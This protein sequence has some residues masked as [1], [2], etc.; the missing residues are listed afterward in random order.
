M[1]A[2]TLG[3]LSIVLTG[4]ASGIGRQLATD[5]YRLGHRIVATDVNEPAMRE[6]GATHWPDPARVE[7]LALDVRDAEAWERALDRAEARFVEI[8]VL[9][10]VAGYLVARWAHETSVADVGLTVDVNVKGVMFGTNAAVRRMLRRGRGHVVNVASIGGIVPVPGLA[11]YSASKHAVRGFSLA[12]AQELRD[13]GIFVTSVC[14]G[15]VATPMLDVQLPRD[16][17]ALTFSSA[18]ALSA[19]Q[20]STAII[21]RVLTDRPLEL[22]LPAPRS[23]QRVLARLVGAFPALG[24]A[25]R[26]VLTRMG[27]RRQEKMR[28]G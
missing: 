20:V 19:E 2:R 6:W 28:R 9:M 8:D 15:P 11:V 23:G 26:P 7:I 18:R 17:A 3:P 12:A 22:V 5:L 16:E 25:V 21:E 1:N 4:C 14:P 10:N 24:S 13:K 27:R